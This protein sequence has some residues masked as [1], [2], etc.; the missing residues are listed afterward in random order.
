VKKSVVRRR[1]LVV[2]AVHRGVVPESRVD[3]Q[4]GARSGVRRSRMPTSAGVE[5]ARTPGPVAELGEASPA[6]SRRR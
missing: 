5:L 1:A 2:E 3:Q 4:V 6:R